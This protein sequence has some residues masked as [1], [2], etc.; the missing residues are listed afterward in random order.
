MLYSISCNA[1]LDSEVL[2]AYCLG[3]PRSYLMT[4]PERELTTAQLDCFNELIRRRLQPQPVAYLVGE[5]EFYSMLLKTTPDTLVPRPETEM[6]V[7]RLLQLVDDIER[8][9]VLELGTGTGAIALALKKHAPQCRVIATDASPAALDVAIANATAH[10]LDIEFLQSDWYQALSVRSFDIIA[11]NPPYI[12]SHDPYL[13]QGD[14][15]A[16]PQMALCSGDSGLEALQTIITGA[17]GFLR[18]GGSIVLEHGYDQQ[19]P[20]VELLQSTGFVDIHCAR[21]F[22]DLPRLTTARRGE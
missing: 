11:S 7:D 8:P 20:V 14:L 22:N 5:R 16:E 12:A 19:Q 21:D 18:P 3:K 1:R 6:L 2:L 10:E 13:R 15:P 4:W 9:E 17:P